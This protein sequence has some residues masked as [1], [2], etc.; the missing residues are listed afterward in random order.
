M[1]VTEVSNME[2][3]PGANQQPEGST[4][5][6]RRW[7]WIVLILLIAGG[8]VG[9]RIYGPGKPAAADQPAGGRGGR[10]GRGE[11]QAVSVAVAPVEKKDVPFYLSGLGSVTAF[12]TVT[13]HP[14]V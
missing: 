9:Y 3:R 7:I 14:R 5:K 2:V 4:G 1:S 13:V 12:N 6:S 10:G 8:I 11:G